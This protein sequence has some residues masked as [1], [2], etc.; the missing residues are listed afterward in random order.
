MNNQTLIIKVGTSTLTRRNDDGLI[1]LDRDSFRNIGRQIQAFANSSYRI[2]LVSSAA[3]SAGMAISGVKIRPDNTELAMPTLQ[4]LASIGWR[5]VLNSWGEVLNQK[6]GEVLI[7]SKELDRETERC[8]LLQVLHNL[9]SHGYVPVIN[10]NDVIT[11]EEIAFGDNDIL[12]AHLAVKLKE[13]KL[14][15]D[16]VSIILLSNIDGVYE[17]I[18]DSASRI[19]HIDDIDNYLE[20]LDSTKS[21]GGSGGMLSKFNA[22]R[23]VTGVGIDLFIANGRSSCSIQNALDENGGTRFIKK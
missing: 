4:S 3:I 23:I 12:T 8:E 5:H 17:D 13:S 9:T 14:F 20:N 19:S 6:I 2:I 10:E 18:N 1:A 21:D 15:G 22:A 7:T 16:N 11:H